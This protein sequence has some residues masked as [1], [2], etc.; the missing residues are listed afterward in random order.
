MKTEHQKI[1]DLQKATAWICQK[2]N[3]MPK[4]SCCGTTE[5]NIQ[6][7]FLEVRPFADGMVFDGRLYVYVALS[8]DNCSNTMFFNAKKIGLVDDASP[9][10]MS[11]TNQVA[12]EDL[13]G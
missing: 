10:P 13:G 3:G 7:D 6:K 11:A 5:W 4:C 12:G 9:I 2:S 1:I 8:C